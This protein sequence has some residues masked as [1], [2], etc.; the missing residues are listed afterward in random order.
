MSDTDAVTPR[1]AELYSSSDGWRFR[2]KA[3]NGETLATG[4]SY[5]DKRDAVRAIKGLAPDV[6]IREVEA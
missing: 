5:V 2:I 3:G 4:E 6:P 1:Y